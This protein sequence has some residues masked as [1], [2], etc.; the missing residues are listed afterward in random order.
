MLFFC[1]IILSVIIKVNMSKIILI[2]D[3]I[4]SIHNVGSILRTADG[5]GVSSVLFC[6]YTPYPKLKDDSR[7]PH[8]FEKSTRAI[9]KT[10]LGAETTVKCAIYASTKDAITQAKAEGYVIV[11][12]EQSKSSI[13]LQTY[14]STQ[15]VAI[16]L[17]NEVEGITSDTLSLCDVIIEI[18]MFGKKESFNVSVATAICLYELTKET[19]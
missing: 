16:V 5:F 18:P 14:N 19:R 13:P 7:L 9:H 12:L 3:N 10:A 8:E 6:G 11:A 15:P 17:G 2:L 1:Y 4:R